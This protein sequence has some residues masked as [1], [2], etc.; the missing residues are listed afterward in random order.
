MWASWKESYDKGRQ[1]N[2]KQKH[3]FVSKSLYS[4]SY[5]FSS[6]HGWMWELDNKEGWAPKEVCFWTV[7]LENTF[8]S[9]LDRKVIELVNPKGTQPW[10]FIGRT[11]TDAEAK[12]PT[13][14]LSD[15]KSWLTGK[16]LEDEKDWGQEEKGATE[17]E[18][19]GWYYW[20]NGHEFE[21]ALG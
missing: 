20:L 18:I 13:F 19:V 1:S 11:D 9:L 2:K 3:H 15:V 6:S 14:W 4:Q 21:Q 8:E 17:D 16:D 7:V 10:I 5:V 12:A